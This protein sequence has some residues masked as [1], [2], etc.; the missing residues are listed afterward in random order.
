MAQSTT[1]V[2]KLPAEMTD[3]ELR[4]AK[5]AI[6]DDLEPMQAKMNTL[7]QAN[8]HLDVEINNRFRLGNAPTIGLQAYPLEG[9][10]DTYGSKE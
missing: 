1:W 2:D 10:K 4:A 6:T 3:E 8:Q 9:I 5:N 7:A